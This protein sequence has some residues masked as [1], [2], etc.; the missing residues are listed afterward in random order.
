MARLSVASW[1]GNAAAVLL[2]RDTASFLLWFGACR[3]EDRAA[4]A[5]DARV[6]DLTDDWGRTTT[7]L[8]RGIADSC[9]IRS[10]RWASSSSLTAFLQRTC[11]G[12][13]RS[14]DAR[15]GGAIFW[16]TA[17]RAFGE[18][19][20]RG[21]RRAQEGRISYTERTTHATC[22]RKTRLTIR[23]QGK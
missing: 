18:R 8:G 19:F 2:M 1:I 23:H 9:A 3:G 13:E 4:Y 17:E 16:L 12:S 20:G 21:Y 10:K 7:E 22:H 6:L 11:K 15:K 5:A 14:Q